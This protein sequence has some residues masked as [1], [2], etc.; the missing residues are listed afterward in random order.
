MILFSREKCV[1]GDKDG[2]QRNTLRV[3]SYSN[4]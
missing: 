3:C 1:N 4:D 2:I